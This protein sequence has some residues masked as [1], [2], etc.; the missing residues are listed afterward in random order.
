MLLDTLNKVLIMLFFLSA[1]NVVRHVYFLIQTW[2]SSTEETPVK[3]KLKSK[4]I[5]LLGVSLA[6]I[7]TSIFTGIKL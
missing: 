3:Y 1:F 5:F 4:S 2:V 6:Y 7:L